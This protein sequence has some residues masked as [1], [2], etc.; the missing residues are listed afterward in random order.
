MPVHASDAECGDAHVA[1]NHLSV[2]PSKP[3]NG[4][5]MGHS[6]QSLAALLDLHLY[7]PGGD[8]SMTVGGVAWPVD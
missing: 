5:T 8:V 1:T 7:R 6:R 3:R 2:N 4:N